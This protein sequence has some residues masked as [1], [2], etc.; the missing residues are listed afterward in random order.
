[1]ST[2]NTNIGN[3]NGGYD[4]TSISIGGVSQAQ[5]DA[6]HLDNEYVIK[7]PEDLAPWDI[8]T[9][10]QLDDAIY[11]CSVF[12]LSKPLYPAKLVGGGL[13]PATIIEGGRISYVGTGGLFQDNPDGELHGA[14]AFVKSIFFGN[15][16]NLL[17]DIK[18]LAIGFGVLG[19][20]TYGS[21]A[22][23]ILKNVPDILITSQRFIDPQG[24][25]IIIDCGQVN[26]GNDIHEV[27][28][29]LPEIYK[30]GGTIDVFNINN[31][32]V[33]INNSVTNIFTIDPTFN[34]ESPKIV[35]YATKYKAGLKNGRL[36]TT[37]LTGIG[38]AADNGAGGV[39]INDA[40]AH[41]LSTGDGLCVGGANDYRY[42]IGGY[43][44]KTIDP[45][46]FDLLLDYGVATI[47]DG[48]GGLLDIKTDFKHRLTNGDSITITN[49]TSYNNTYI[50]S[51]VNPLTPDIFQITEAY[52]ADESGNYELPTPFTTA[53]DNFRWDTGSLN[54]STPTVTSFLNG[55]EINSSVLLTYSLSSIAPTA[56]TIAWTPIAITATERG[57]GNQRLTVFNNGRVYSD[58]PKPVILDVKSQIFGSKFGGASF[59]LE[60]SYLVNGEITPRVDVSVISDSWTDKAKG[61]DINS[62]LR[63][64]Q[65]DYYQ[66]AARSISGPTSITLGNSSSNV[67]GAI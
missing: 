61:K 6:T 65:G 2:I 26:I 47:T 11:I 5:L 51:G 40:I 44:A 4:G 54:E 28:S 59:D 32:N 16:T 56:I 53:G 19:G 30:L 18:K 13:I 22:G 41:A 20:A 64:N 21:F 33:I 66:L 52:V 46:N 62:F 50:V 14:L 60:F 3:S 24:P 63:L 37:G 42:N 43:F 36:F 9:G 55:D 67:K 57:A 15:G 1:M 49:T 10:Y 25:A 38:T 35:N 23:Y 39:R 58:S 29:S 7:T 34:C 12:E 27:T 8:G 17:M 31:S 48:G 45:N